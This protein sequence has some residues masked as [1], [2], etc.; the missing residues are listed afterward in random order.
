MEN[1]NSLREHLLYLFNGDGAHLDFDSAIKGLPASVRN[2]KPAGAAHS[3]WETLEHL[4]ITQWDVLESIRNAKHVSPEFP[5][6][7][8]PGTS[9][10][11]GEKAWSKSVEAFRRDREALAEMIASRSTDLL[12]A[13][14]NG[15]GQ[16]VFRKVAMLADH[17]A[18]HL[19]Q[20]IL[21][22]RLLGAWQ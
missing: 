4:R 20:L 19:G 7:Y 17:N 13:L 18:Y 9:T 14:P 21:L 16:T 6:G 10:S 22:R 5:S 3:P 15:D 12:A 1:H 8:W 11:E 2:K